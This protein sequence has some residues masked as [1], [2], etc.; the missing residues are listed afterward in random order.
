MSGMQFDSEGKVARYNPNS[1][2]VTPFQ[3][4]VTHQGLD[5]AGNPVPIRGHVNMGV[6]AQVNGGAQ[7]V[8]VGQGAEAFNG[9]ERDLGPQRVRAADLPRQPGMA[10][11]ASTVSGAPKMP[12]QL[13]A[14]DLVSINL[15]DGTPTKSSVANAVARGWLKPSA[16][17]GYE[18]VEPAQP[19]R[20]TSQ[21]PSAQPS[22]DPIS[23]HVDL[24]DV[25][26]GPAA[27]LK[28][29][30]NDALKARAVGEMVARGELSPATIHAAAAQLDAAPEAVAQVVSQALEGYGKQLDRYVAAN[31][32]A[33]NDFY[34]WMKGNPETMASAMVAHVRTGSPASAY[35]GLLRQFKAGRR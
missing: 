5:A 1:G 29:G 23:T 21:P 12:H 3:D 8:Y 22:V 16:N 7:R 33:P 26:S 19:Q 17:G 9:I 6:R 25:Y 14:D 32:I 20:P 30:V 28:H 2:N 10:D 4:I 11:S 35:A 24:D 15:S 18:D 27:V 31:G 13:K 34:A